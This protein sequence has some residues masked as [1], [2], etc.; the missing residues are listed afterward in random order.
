LNRAVK[1]AAVP[2]PVSGLRAGRLARRLCDAGFGEPTI[3]APLPDER[4]ISI[5][6]P[7][8]DDRVMRY[9]FNNLLRKNSPLVRAAITAANAGSR[10]GLLRHLVPFSFMLFRTSE[11]GGGAG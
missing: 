8:D 9:C 4:D 11:D 6:V 1:R 7:I 3:L 5:V 2:R 10:L